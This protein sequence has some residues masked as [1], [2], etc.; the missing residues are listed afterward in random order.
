MAQDGAWPYARVAAEDD[1]QIRAA[2]GGGGDAHHRVAGFDQPRLPACRHLHL[3]D[4]SQYDAL[5]ARDLLTRAP[6][7]R[8]R[9]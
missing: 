3:T 6:R 8:T 2:D 5:H 9:K 1:V 4:T 7:R